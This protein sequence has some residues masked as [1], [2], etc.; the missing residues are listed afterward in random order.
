MSSPAS[1]LTGAVREILVRNLPD[2]TAL[3]DDDVPLRELGL[4]SLRMV[5]V[6]VALR[7]ELGSELPDDLLRPET[8]HT[9]RSLVSALRAGTDLA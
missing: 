3:V 8:F 6:V 2:G 5:R 4:S 1:S 9:V 7:E